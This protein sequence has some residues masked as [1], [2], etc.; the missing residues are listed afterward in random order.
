[1]KTIFSIIFIFL[2]NSASLFAQPSTQPILRIETGMHTAIVNRISTDS[3]N[4]F[5]L[6][7]SDDKTA[8]LWDLSDGRLLQV[9]RPPIGDGNEG[10]LY[11]AALS[12][13]GNFIA[14]GG[15]TKAGENS[16]SIYIF[17][18]ASSRL[19]CRL[20]SLPN[21]IHHLIFSPD[22]RLLSA[23]LGAGNGVRLYET[24]NWQQIGSDTDYGSASYGAD[25]DKS[26]GRLVTSC[27]DG[28]LR[29][30][31]VQANGLRLLSKQTAV[32]GKQP[33]SVKFSPDGTKIAVGFYNSTAVNVFSAS[34]LSFL[35]APDTTGV[36]NGNLGSVV[37]S[38]D[39]NTLLAGGRY[40]K[41]GERQLLSWSNGGRGSYREKAT[42][43]N[44]IMDIQPLQTG[45]VI[46]GTA[47]PSWGIIDGNGKRTKFVTSQIADYWNM[48]ANFKVSDD[49]MEIGF[50]YEYAGKSPKVFSLSEKTLTEKGSGKTLSPPKTDSLNIT[51]WEDKYEPK[52]NGKKLE[53][54]LYEMSRSLAIAPDNQKFLLGT[55]WR[56]RL[57]DRNGTELWNAAV[58]GATWSVNISGN[59]KLA[60]VAFGDG[61]IRWHRMTDGKE[62]AAFFPHKDQQR[63]VVWTPSGYYDTVA[64]GE[65]LIGWHVNNGKDAAAD[66]FPV[67]LFRNQF[68]RPDVVSKILYTTDEALA[69]KF[70]NEEANRR[71]QPTTTVSQQLPPVVNIIS[72]SDNSEVSNNTVT[73]R[74]NVR[75]PSG[76][77]V[78]KVRFMID[79]RPV[80]A[81]GVGNRPVGEQ[82]ATIN[83][84]EKDSI[85]SIVAENQYAVSDAAAVR[86]KWKG[87]AQIFKPTLY[88]LAIGISK[89]QNG[90]LNL[91]YAAKDANDFVNVMMKQKGLLYKDVVVKSLT[92]EQA[93]RIEILDGLYWISRETTSRDVAMVFMAGHG[94]NDQ[95]GQYYFL[96]HDTNPD[97]LKSTGVVFSEIENTIKNLAGKTLFFVDTCKSANVLGSGLKR[98]VPDVTR[99]VNE[100]SSAENGAVVFTA[101]TKNQASLED[102][103][104]NNGAFTKA[105]VE[106]LSGQA[107]RQNTGRITITMLDLYI[108]ERVKQITGGRQSPVTRKPD[109]VPDFPIAVKQ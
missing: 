52:L 56:L 4:R 7:A 91:N 100:L 99:I 39:G 21:V 33:F 102:S 82:T 44:T 71:N 20:A 101:S 22:G 13:N 45:G 67:G 55:E 69:L 73:V 17:D 104:W 40:G 31:A 106:G 105:L 75:A 1:M 60:I 93:T 23:E 90:N 108:T 36:D 8:R 87:Q 66:F 15:W 85:L 2:I 94:E 18:R 64:G 32:G 28:Y 10:K 24:N 25:F 62:L 35:F 58:P 37:W 97:K 96:P 46:Y 42:S 49:G 80:E 3:A 14:L 47:D 51:D 30:Y 34:D 26:S 76:E 86:L 103:V 48:L 95:F 98:E 77:P 12:P 29:L 54:Q 107:D 81:R 78:T 57:F 84:P 63:W 65:D 92:N 16:H 70:A 38:R 27:D 41:S 72:P 83:I 5:L 6:T 88:I 53:L 89:Y 50:G 11:S 59:G 61:T 43:N 109:T 79:G 74:Y 9:F 19:L 68:Y